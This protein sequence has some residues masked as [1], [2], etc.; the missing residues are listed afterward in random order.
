MMW[1]WPWRRRTPTPLPPLS[2][3]Q[4]EIRALEQAIL[5][6]RNELGGAVS[7]LDTELRRFERAMQNTGGA[8]RR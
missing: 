4:E 1:P 3:T 7:K 6:Q 8:A 2:P 5:S